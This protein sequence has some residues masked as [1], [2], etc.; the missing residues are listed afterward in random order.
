MIRDVEFIL[1]ARAHE[2][3]TFGPTCDD[4][5]E[6]ERDRFATL[7]GAIEDGVV[8]QFALVVD[9]Y[10]I[11]SSRLV[12]FSLFDHLILQAGFSSLNAF[13]ASVIDEP[14]LVLFLP[15]AE[16]FGQT[17]L[18]DVL[19]SFLVRHHIIVVVK[20][21]DQ[22]LEEDIELHFSA[23]E[24]L[25]TGAIFLKVADRL[26]E[27]AS[28]DISCRAIDLQVE[29]L[30]DSFDQDR[31]LL[32]FRSDGIRLCELRLELLCI[33]YAKHIVNR[34]EEISQFNLSSRLGA[35]TFF[36]F[37]LYALRHF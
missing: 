30:V 19:V 31:E 27:L 8:D 18:T 36:S 20:S 21:V 2:L 1:C 3:K 5:S 32:F 10:C 7:I 12:S 26:T 37:I 23:A 11:Y 22:T 13:F 34:V 29:A 25:E 9:S 28:T 6:A 14:L 33:E 4:L 35:R 24:V 16:L 15:L 17:E